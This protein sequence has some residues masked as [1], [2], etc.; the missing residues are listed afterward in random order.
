MT[1]TSISPLDKKERVSEI[2]RMLGGEEISRAAL[3]NA[4]ELMEMAK[5]SI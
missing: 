4:E 5:N 2:A 3:Q 1:K